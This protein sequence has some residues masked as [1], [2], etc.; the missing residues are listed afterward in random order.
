MG[1][2]SP[3]E[4]KD[5]P[6]AFKLKGSTKFASVFESKCVENN[7]KRLQNNIMLKSVEMGNKISTNLGEKMM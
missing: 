6:R 2:K 3:V 5:K 1:K 4:Q 7:N